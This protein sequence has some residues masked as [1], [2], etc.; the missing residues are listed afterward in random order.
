MNHAEFKRR[1]DNEP[2][3]QQIFA[4]WCNMLNNWPVKVLHGFTD[5]G[6]I[7]RCVGFSMC[8]VADK[9][10]TGVRGFGLYISPARP[11]EFVYEIAGEFYKE[12]MV[13]QKPL[14]TTH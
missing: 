2:E 6:T 4:Y 5:P 14:I 1:I 7:E 8:F 10:P 11:N 9:V 13:V 12:V 3:L